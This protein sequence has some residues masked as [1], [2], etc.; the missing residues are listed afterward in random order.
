MIEE[1]RITYPFVI[2]GWVVLPDHVH[3]IWT[4]QDGDKEFSKRW[5]LIK[6]GFTKHM[7]PFLQRHELL[8]ESR[9]RHQEGTIWQRRFWEH[10]IRDDDDYRKHIDYMHYN[11]VKHGLVK[12]TR[13]WPHSSFHEYCRQGMYPVDWG[14]ETELKFL[15]DFGE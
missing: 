9:K 8:T 5:G 11:P 15:G 14:D 4:L 10:H 13:D 7:K 6:A 12:R 3:C 1:V 2:E